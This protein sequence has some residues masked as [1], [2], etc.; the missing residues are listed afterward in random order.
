MKFCIHC[1][2]Q[3]TDDTAF[4]PYCGEKQTGMPNHD[5]QFGFGGA[6]NWQSTYFVSP[7]SKVV[8]ALLCFFLGGLG[9][10]RFYVGKISSGL[11]MMFLTVFGFV[12][13]LPLIVVGIWSLVDFII[14]ICGYF[15]DGQGLLI[16]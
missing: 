5:G 3:I 11:A 8:T 12:L 15:K 1:G 13:Y 9:I 4:C 6:N 2:R 10:H 16:K 7:K 14:I